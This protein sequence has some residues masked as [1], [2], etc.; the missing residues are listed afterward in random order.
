M[1][2]T[3][4]QS[5]FCVFT[6]H[7]VPIKTQTKSSSKSNLSYLHS[8]MYLLKRLTHKDSTLESVIFTFHNVPIKTFL[9]R[10]TCSCQT[11]LHSTMYLLKLKSSMF[12]RTRLTYLH[13]TMYLL[14]QMSPWRWRMPQS[15][16]TFH[17]V[18]IKT[19]TQGWY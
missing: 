12:P 4:I 9:L 13:S 6:F 3:L 11:Y 17:N 14:K 18:P 2:D 10:C 15:A 8:T 5:T 19:R 1:P 16:F 7:N